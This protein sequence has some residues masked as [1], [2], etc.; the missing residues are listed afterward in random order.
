MEKGGCCRG[1]GMGTRLQWKKVGKG[2][3]GGGSLELLLVGSNSNQDLIIY[4]VECIHSTYNTTNIRDMLLYDVLHCILRMAEALIAAMTLN[5]P[6]ENEISQNSN[7]INAHEV[8]RVD[9][10]G[11]GQIRIHK[12]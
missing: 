12:R 11:V 3:G 5:Q 6:Q 10:S 1:K 2:P 4:S 7:L 9:L 8:S